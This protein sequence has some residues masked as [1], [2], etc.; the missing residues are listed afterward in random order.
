MGYTCTRPARVPRTC[1]TQLLALYFAVRQKQAMA[2]LSR[3]ATSFSPSTAKAKRNSSV[4]RRG[5]ATKKVQANS[6]SESIPEVSIIVFKA[7]EIAA[8][9]EVDTLLVII[10]IIGF[11][12]MVQVHLL[13]N[14]IVVSCSL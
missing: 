8:V 14:L 6:I 12:F 4:T 2:K 9:A 11:V 5:I 13:L 3:T 7:T 1:I 10:E